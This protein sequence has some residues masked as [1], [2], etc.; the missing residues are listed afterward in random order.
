MPK[1]NVL[2]NPHYKV[3]SGVFKLLDLSEQQSKINVKFTMTQDKDKAAD[4]HNGHVGT[5]YS[6]WHC[7]FR[8]KRTI[9][10]LLK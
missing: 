4:A 9:N 10:Q 2:K 7:G 6:I 1:K 8:D 3:L 5:R